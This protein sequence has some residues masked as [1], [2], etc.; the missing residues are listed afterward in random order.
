MNADSMLEELVPTTVESALADLLHS[1]PV[2][3]REHE[4][5]VIFSDFYSSGWEEMLGRL[6]GVNRRIVFIH[7]M[8]PADH[9]ITE[10]MAMDRR[11]RRP[12]EWTDEN[13]HHVCNLRKQAQRDDYNAKLARGNDGE[14]GNE[15][16]WKTLEAI[17][18]AT[19]IPVIVNQ[20]VLGAT[21]RIWQD[22]RFIA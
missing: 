5:L 6:R 21:K 7:V 2:S 20:D 1:V 4:S 11:C 13:G 15:Y 19:V 3:R 8:D 14:S 10:E 17:P 16:I 12:I 9:Q 18:G 22:P